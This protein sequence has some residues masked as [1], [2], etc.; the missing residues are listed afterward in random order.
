M[1]YR[2][3]MCGMPYGMPCVDGV[4]VWNAVCMEGDVWNAVSS[5]IVTAHLKSVSISQR[6]MGG[7]RESG[8]VLH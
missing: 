2:V 7:S 3:L 1:E 8:N 5:Q 6:R 4:D